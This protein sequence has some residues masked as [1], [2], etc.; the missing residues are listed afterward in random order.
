MDQQI[1]FF[2]SQSNKSVALC[3]QSVPDVQPGGFEGVA[4]PAMVRS[5]YRFNIG[6]L[7]V[8]DD[9]APGTVVAAI[10]LNRAEGSAR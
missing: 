2:H 9:F 7:S 3:S 10:D 4:S 1:L 8:G 6:A 5:I